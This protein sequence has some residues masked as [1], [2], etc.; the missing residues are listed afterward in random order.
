MKTIRVV[1]IILAGAAVIAVL[2]YALGVKAADVM[3][4]RKARQE[5]ADLTKAVLEKMGTGLGVGVPLPDGAF[6]DLAGAKVRLSELTCG[7]T[8]IVYVEPDCGHCVNQIKAMSKWFTGNA[9]LCGILIS[10]VSA[11]GLREFQDKYG[12]DCRLLSDIDGRYKKA[13]HILSFP[14]NFIVDKN[15]RIQ[16]VDLGELAENEIESLTTEMAKQ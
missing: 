7:K 11:D 16:D 5:R 13:V 12:I 4:E 15:L 6:E 2:A 1:V 8:L 14:S 3:A 10:N 9:K